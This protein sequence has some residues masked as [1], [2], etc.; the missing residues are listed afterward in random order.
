MVNPLIVQ[1]VS[2]LILLIPGYIWS[3]SS[4]PTRT[5]MKIPTTIVASFF[6]RE[7]DHCRRNLNWFVN[8]R[9]FNDKYVNLGTT[10]PLSVSLFIL[11]VSIVGMM[12]IYFFSNH[13][14]I[15]WRKQILK[16]FKFGDQ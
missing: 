3:I 1:L 5:R 8:T 10:N 6:L 9:F 7:V 13:V 14:Y 16:L 11:A 12:F 4:F 2:V 15:R